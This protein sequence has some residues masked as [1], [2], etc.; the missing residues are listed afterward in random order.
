MKRIKRIGSLLLA[1][2]LCG[3][4]FACVEAQNVQDAFARSPEGAMIGR[5]FREVEAAF[6]PF[7]MAFLEEDQPVAC[8]FSKTNVLFYFDESQAM[9]SWRTILTNGV[10]YIP[11]AIAL[12][13][14]QG[15]DVCIGVSGRIRDFGIAD[16]DVEKMAGYM[17]FFHLPSTETKTNTVYTVTTTDQAYDVY[18]YCGLGETAVTADHRIQVMAAGASAAPA[19]EPNVTEFTFGEAVIPVGATEVEVRGTSSVHKT[20]TAKEFADLVKYCPHLTSLVVDCCDVAGEEQIGKLTEL[21]KLELMSCGIPDIAFVRNLTELTWLS[22]CHNRIS[23]ITPIEDL[24]LTYLNLG[25]NPDLR[26]S[27]LSS[28]GMLTSLDSLYLYTLD[29]SSLSSLKHLKRVTNLNLNSCSRITEENF[30]KV[31]NMIHLKTLRING[32]SVTNLD[33]LFEYFTELKELEARKLKK[34]ENY[35]QSIFKLAEHPS[36]KKLTLSKDKQPDLDAAAAVAY[37]M[38]AS[39]YFKSHGITVTYK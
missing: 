34:L 12:R 31:A 30:E 26:N 6:G 15:T 13:D 39:D 9:A 8:V 37:E 27:D 11:G 4:L 17:Q 38:S 36:L 23:D 10:G 20:I 18:I 1:L 25:D 32:T 19:P 3:G 35:E 16:S 2:L 24:P 29:I 5:T 28:V 33:F 21:T 22:L 7:A 14:I